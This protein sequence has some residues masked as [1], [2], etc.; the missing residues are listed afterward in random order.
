MVKVIENYVVQD[1]IGKG[2]YGDVHLGYNKDTKEKVAIKIM[3]RNKING[4]MQELL[5]NEIKA[6]LKCNDNANII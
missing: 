3:K 6:M 4:K 5:E 2:Q 1:I